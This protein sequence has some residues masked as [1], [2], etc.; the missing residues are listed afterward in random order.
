MS[1]H[2]FMM[3][4]INQQLTFRKRFNPELSSYR[5]NNF[6]R[7]GGEGGGIYKDSCAEFLVIEGMNELFHE[8]YA[9]AGFG[10]EFYVEGG[11]LDFGCGGGTSVESQFLT[12]GVNRR[13]EGGTLS[14]LRFRLCSGFGGRIRWG[15]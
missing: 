3:C 11:E 12:S 14:R 1:R 4:N 9:D 6:G 7:L 5:R 15:C 10:G 2:K 13:E 8:V